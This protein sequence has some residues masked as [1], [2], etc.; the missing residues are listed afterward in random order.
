SPKWVPQMADTPQ[1]LSHLA[2]NP[3]PRATEITYPYLVPNL[4]GLQRALELPGAKE[5]GLKEIAI[6][7]SASEGFSRKN[8]NCTIEESLERF[9]PVLALAKQHNIAVRGYI[10][11]IF[12]C[13][14]DGPTPPE[15]VAKVTKELLDL[16]CYEISLGDTN[17]SGTPQSV[18]KLLETL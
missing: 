13:P 12:S 10:S 6:F 17:G 3:P 5:G 14:Y 4:V 18:S 8:I 7:A 1:L 9:K 15:T 2:A 11:M 16:G